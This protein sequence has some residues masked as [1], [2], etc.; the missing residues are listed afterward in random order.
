L[1]LI[2]LA[3]GIE[4]EMLDERLAAFVSVRQ[5]RAYAAADDLSPRR[6]RCARPA[7]DSLHLA[8]P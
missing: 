7:V 4:A 8:K 1:R 3:S 6:P 5:M 2:D